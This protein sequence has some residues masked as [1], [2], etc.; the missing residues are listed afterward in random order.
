MARSGVRVERKVIWSVFPLGWVLGGCLHGGA[1]I[2]E[3]LHGGWNGCGYF[4]VD[5]F[6][7]GFVGLSRT[8]CD[9][10]G[11]GWR[12]LKRALTQDLHGQERG[13]EDG[14]CGSPVG[15]CQ[16]RPEQGASRYGHRGQIPELA[17][18]VGAG[19][20]AEEGDRLAQDGEF[21]GALFA[22]EDM[23]YGGRNAGV[24]GIRGCCEQIA[25]LVFSEVRV[26]GASKSG[27][28]RSGCW[29]RI[30]RISFCGGL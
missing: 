15:R 29:L 6:E 19:C 12:R 7:E 26:D 10:G 25:E 30:H 4:T 3:R 20:V 17:V 11:S 24:G 18:G 28:V 22:G 5:V 8:I 27:D 16:R 21:A 13:E 2:C 14:G 9:A 23:G 1:W